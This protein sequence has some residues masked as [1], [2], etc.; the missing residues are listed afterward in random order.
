VLLAEGAETLP[1]ELPD[2]L[3]G[4]FSHDYLSRFCGFPAGGRRQELQPTSE[5]KRYKPP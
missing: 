1:Q 2:V 4:S 3:D 5:V